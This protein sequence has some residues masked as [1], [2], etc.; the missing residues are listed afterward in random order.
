[1]TKLIIK[2]KKILPG[3]YLPRK[4]E[5]DATEDGYDWHELPLLVKIADFCYSLVPNYDG[6]LTKLLLESE[7]APQIK[8]D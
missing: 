5:I 2:F 8:E 6:K 7:N 1:M 4:V 3:I